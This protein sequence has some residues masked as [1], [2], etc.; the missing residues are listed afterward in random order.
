MS[1]TQLRDLR[2]GG[3]KP[4]D[5]T[6]LIG[7]PGVD[8]EDGPDKV[9]ITRSDQDLSPLVGLRVHVIDLQNDPKVTLRAIAA[10]EALNVLPM[11]VCGPAGACGV[12]PEHEYAM[13]SYRRTLCPTA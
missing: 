13:E 11:G 8:F 4:A 9:L 10:M 5:V 6:V 7:K 1:L 2:R 12:S 3:H